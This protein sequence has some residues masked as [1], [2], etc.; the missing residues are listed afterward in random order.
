MALINC[1]E[2]SGSL[3]SLASTCPHCGMPQKMSANARP[4]PLAKPVF[5]TDDHP[6]ANQPSHDSQ[7][8]GPTE[9]VPSKRPEEP[10]DEKTPKSNTSAEIF[11]WLFA[12]LVLF[13]FSKLFPESCSISY[14]PG[15]RGTGYHPIPIPT[16]SNQTKSSQDKGV[17]DAKTLEQILKMHSRE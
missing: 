11:G 5:S 1:A 17:L 13:I 14:L 3:S 8:T 4:A 7:A 16:N 15:L 2:C 9:Q 10:T 12:C 6:N